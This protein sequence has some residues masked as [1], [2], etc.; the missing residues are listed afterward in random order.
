VR[1]LVFCA[2][3]HHKFVPDASKPDEVV[4][5][6]ET[7]TA[8]NERADELLASFDQVQLAGE[9]QKPSRRSHRRDHE[10]ADNDSEVTS[11]T[12]PLPDPAEDHDEST[13]TEVD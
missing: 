5:G 10:E 4:H 12:T 7:F 6:G 9:A 8:S 3:A 1:E 2:P 13:D 11:V